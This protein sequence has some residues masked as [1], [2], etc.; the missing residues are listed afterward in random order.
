MNEM[1]KISHLGAAAQAFVSR[2]GTLLIDGEWVAAASGQTFDAID[3]ATESVICQ[4]AAAD[5]EDV[6]R[7]VKAARRAFEDSAWS[8][9]RP[10]ERERLMLKLADLIEQNAEELAQLESLDNGKPVFFARI[11]DVAGTV[12]FFRYMAGWATKVEGKTLDV[13]PGMPSET[14]SVFPS[15]LVAQPAM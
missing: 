3:P 6:D 7:A 8:R 2:A 14:S 11:V 12:D 9:M 10:V 13:S 15:T 5:K 1:T 4:L